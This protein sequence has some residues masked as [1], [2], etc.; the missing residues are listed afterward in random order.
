MR[1]EGRKKEMKQKGTER[2]KEIKNALWREGIKEA[3]EAGSEE[4]K[5]EEMGGGKEGNKARE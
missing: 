5:E 3:R 4:K 2:R 1:K